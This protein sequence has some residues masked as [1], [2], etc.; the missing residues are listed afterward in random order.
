MTEEEWLNSLSAIGMLGALPAEMTDRKVR[1]FVCACARRV[2][3]R[4]STKEQRNLAASEDYAAGRISLDKLKRLWKW[5][6]DVE[7]RART[8]DGIRNAEIYATVAA[9]SGKK[10]RGRNIRDDVLASERAA[11]ATLVRCIL[12]PLG[13]NPRLETAWLSWDGG[14]VLNLARGIYEDGAFD[15]LPVLADALEEAGCTDTTWLGHLRGPGPHV[16]GCW[17]V[18]VILGKS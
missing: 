8:E 18:D 12:P 9:R 4:L 7:L 14:L 3:G 11:Q 6:Q 1:L 2:W 17:P 5:P 16:L 10:G 15:R 13:R